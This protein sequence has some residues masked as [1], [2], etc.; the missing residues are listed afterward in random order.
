MMSDDVILS[1]DDV[2]VSVRETKEEKNNERVR[3]GANTIKMTKSDSQ[4]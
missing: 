1:R 2:I 3:P 4:R